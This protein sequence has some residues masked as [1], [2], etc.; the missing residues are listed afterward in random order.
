L[1]EKEGVYQFLDSKGHTLY[2]GKA[3]NLRQRVSSYFLNQSVLG[4]KT[5]ILVSQIRKI[6]VTEV[7]SEIEALLLEAYL[8]KKHSPRYNIRLTDGKSYPY[9]RIVLKD[10]YPA[11]LLARKTDD[12]SSIYFGPYPS[13]SSVKLVLRL[14][15]RV[16]PYVSVLNHPKRYCLYYHL[17]LCVCPPMHDTPRLR[18]QYRVYIRRLVAIL[19]GKSKSIMRELIKERDKFSQ[20]EN[21]EQALVIQKQIDSLSYITQPVRKPFE[22][23][24]NPNLRSDIRLKELAKLRDVLSAH[25]LLLSSLKKIECYDI[26]NIQGTNATGSMVVFI[27]GEKCPS[28]YRKFRINREQTPNDFAMMEE[29]LIRRFKHKE[30]E[31]P[32]LIIVDGGKGQISAGLKALVKFSL[33]IPLVGLAKREEK[34][35]LPKFS[36]PFSV[37]L[38]SSAGEKTQIPNQITNGEL[39]SKYLKFIEI[40]LPQDS[41]ALLLLRRVRDEAHRFALTYHKL[42]RSKN[43]LPS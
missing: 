29:V 39:F 22:Y 40:S 17:G 41:S 27:N 16:V 36:P 33:P 19:E 18:R 12:S 11:V 35:I 31:Y 14:L 25:G 20:K 3:K 42:L 28:L 37:N 15:R 9:I 34:L 23:D 10:K 1:P 24:I 43:L 2:V 32:D 5:R 6:K 8:I 7:N 38:L 4:E 13:S 26:S 30:W 21:F